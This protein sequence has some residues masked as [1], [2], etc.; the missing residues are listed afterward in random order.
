[1]P[2]SI[3]II[4]S[5]DGESIAQ[6]NQAFP[7][8]GGEI[9]R[10]FGAIMQLS[11]ASREVSGTHAI[12]R[13]TSRGYQVVDNS[14]NGLFINGSDEPL[15]K[16]NQSTLSDG[17][18]LDIGRYRLL[19][20]CFIPEKAQAQRLTE[21]PAASP[22]GDDPF[23]TELSSMSVELNESEDPQFTISDIEVVDV[24][25]DPFLSDDVMRERQRL[26]FD[27]EFQTEEDDPFGEEAYQASL[28]AAA[29]EPSQF[30]TQPVQLALT[31]FRKHEQRL[32]QQTDKALE[33]AL[34]LLL[35]DISPQATESM[36][37]DLS[38][39]GFWSP[40]PKYWDMYK[41]YFTR[42]ID[43]RD[44]QV[45]FQGYFYDALRLQRNLEGDKQ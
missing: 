20:S 11:D 17:D 40:K 19:V 22:F 25:D 14:T 39:T 37:D 18:V 26:G 21:V 30:E 44:W 6:W 41:R 7:E 2:L 35:A 34:T 1:M 5:P 31:E 10:T 36:F 24:D 3:R 43:N 33:I 29:Q 38:G 16:G 23:R 13:K 15:G 8:E 28:S 32:Q 45:K 9:G 4:S 12:I 42:Q 27:L